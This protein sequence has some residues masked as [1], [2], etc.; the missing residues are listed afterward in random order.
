MRSP[1]SITAFA[2]INFLLIG[3]AAAATEVADSSASRCCGALES[4]FPSKTLSSNN[5]AESQDYQTA[6]LSYFSMQD[7]LRPNCFVQPTSTKDVSKIV[8]LLSKKSCRFAVKSGGHGL[9]VGASNIDE[10]VT[11]DLSQM[12]DVKLSADRKI[13]AVQPGAKW[14]D[15]YSTLDAQ[16]YA[17]P[18]GR[19]GGVGVGGLITGGLLTVV[20]STGVV[21]GNGTVVQAN[22]QTNPDLFTALKGSSNNLGIVTRFDIIAFKQGNLWGGVASYDGKRVRKHIEAFVKFTDSLA[23]YPESSLI[24]IWSYIKAEDTFLFNNLYEYTGNVEGLSESKFPSPAFDEFAPTSPVGSPISST[25]RVANLSSLTGELNSPP[26]LSNL[27]ASIT[28]SNNLTVL[29]GVADIINEEINQIKKED[30]YVYLSFQIQPL[31]RVFVDRGLEQ[32]PNMLVFLFNLAWNGTQYDAKVRQ[33]A[34]QVIGRLQKYTR[35][36]GALKEFQY[37]NYAFEDLDPIGSYGPDNVR[38][39]KDVSAKYDPLRVFQ[40]LVPGGFKLADAGQKAPL[41]GSV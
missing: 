23:Q 36:M 39:I 17:V 9:P 24:F 40:K 6:V 5:E 33:V 27:F 28:F 10:G 2:A 35:S 18:G 21:L 31:P 29:N 37:L 11:I 20:P 19:A 41:P 12:K 26:E 15:V 3:L 22:N 16:G 4:A 7:R 25:L 30:F 14:I 32:G 13:A 8:G 34:G 1:I 38:K